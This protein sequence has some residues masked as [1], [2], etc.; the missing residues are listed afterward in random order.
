MFFLSWF[1]L[2]KV[3]CQ[4]LQSL[5][6]QSERV[7][8]LLARLF[9]E[10]L[11]LGVQSPQAS[12]GP[13]S[14]GRYHLQIAQQFLERGGCRWRLDHLLH[15]Q[16][17]LRLFKK[18]LPDSGRSFPPNG[19]QLPGLPACEL[20][21]RKR[22]G[23]LLTVLET[24]TRHRHQILHRH[25]RGDLARAHLLLHAVGKHL[26][27]G[28]TTRYPTHAAIELSSQFFEAIA[29]SLLQLRQ[30][31]AFFQGA[32]GLRPTQRTDRHQS[33]D[34]AQRPE[35]CFNRVPAQLLESRDA[36]VTVDHHIAIWLIRHSDDHDRGL[37]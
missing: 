13:L 5:Q 3:C 4:T 20:V 25:L 9:L 10:W 27:Q 11:A 1:V 19:I 8:Q 29:E 34:F 33:L 31:P 21:P 36:L 14:D 35:H 12:V 37:L 18:A 6:G 22:D 16:K 17:Q 28:Q 32:V 2:W 30:Q 24:R 26:D 7:A 15:L 23:H